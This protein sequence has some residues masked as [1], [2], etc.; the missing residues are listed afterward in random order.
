VDFGISKVLAEELTTTVGARGITPGYSPPEQYGGT[1]DA[2]SDIYALG[3]T[4][5]AVLAGRKPTDSVLLMAGNEPLLPPSM[6]NDTLKPATEEAILK[7]MQLDR[8]KRFDDI[9]SLLAALER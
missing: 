5:Y 9:S 2:R 3:A 8:S 4:L 6:I 7:A 1:T